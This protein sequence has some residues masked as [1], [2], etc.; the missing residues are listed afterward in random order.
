[1]MYRVE[2]H[3]LW[4]PH[5]ICFESTIH[6]SMPSNNRISGFGNNLREWTYPKKDRNGHAN[7]RQGSKHTHSTLI[8]QCIEH[9][10][11]EQRKCSATTWSQ[12]NRWSD[13]TSKVHVIR[14]HK[15][16]C[17]TLQDL[18]DT[19]TKWCAR[20]DRHYP[21]N[22]RLWCPESWK[23]GPSSSG[24]MNAL[25]MRTTRDPQ[26]QK[27]PPRWPYVNGWQAATLCELKEIRKT[28][29]AYASG[30]ARPVSLWSMLRR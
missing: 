28:V 17:E 29:R 11:T 21:M 8:S 27:H 18:C 1:M 7:S 30:G 25:A 16:R 3:Y 26:G 23:W 22:I 13:S 2:D 12:N 5:E 20:K 15:V 14:I 24:S 19:K 9:T 4:K 6:I 10:R